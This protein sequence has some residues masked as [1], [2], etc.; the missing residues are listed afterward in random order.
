MPGT[1]CGTLVFN[2]GK[3]KKS[4]AELGHTDLLSVYKSSFTQ[5]PISQENMNVFWSDSITMHTC[6]IS[7]R[8]E[9]THGITEFLTASRR[10]TKTSRKEKNPMLI[11]SQG[12]SFADRYFSPGS[13]CCSNEYWAQRKADNKRKLKYSPRC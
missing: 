11:F 7:R 1:Y 9:K 3:I 12:N 4:R 2:I 5:M 10:E 6:H 13:R 8:E